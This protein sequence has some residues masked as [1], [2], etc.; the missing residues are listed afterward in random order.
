ML[1]FPIQRPCSQGLLLHGEMIAV[2]KKE[3]T[4]KMIPYEGLFSILTLNSGQ[5]VT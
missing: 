2:E 5:I 4:S 3:Q 1:I